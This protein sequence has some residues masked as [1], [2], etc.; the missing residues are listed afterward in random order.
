MLRKARAN[1]PWSVYSGKL[2]CSS[3]PTTPAV[4]IIRPDALTPFE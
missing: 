2:S 4:K 1:W 3:Q